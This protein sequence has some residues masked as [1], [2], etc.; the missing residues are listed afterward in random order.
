MEISVDEAGWL[1]NIIAAKI[2]E[3][4]KEQKEVEDILNSNADKD[5][6]NKMNSWY[7]DEINH[8]VA[9]FIRCGT[10]AGIFKSIENKA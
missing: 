1:T 5:S 9:I 8:L 7:N 10:H 6:L 4:H 3:L 2:S